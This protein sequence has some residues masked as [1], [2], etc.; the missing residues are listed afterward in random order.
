MSYLATHGTGFMIPHR[1]KYRQLPAFRNGVFP[2]M[3]MGGLETR[4]GS[5]G[6]S[7]TGLP[8]ATI[9]WFYYITIG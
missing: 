8:L 5:Q 2:V 9:L 3:F 7:A 1:L 6:I 4:A